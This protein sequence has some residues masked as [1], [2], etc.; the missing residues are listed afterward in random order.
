MIKIRKKKNFKNLSIFI[1]VLILLSMILL[2]GCSSYLASV[3]GYKITQQ[4]VGKYTATLKTT[5]PELF[6]EENK[7]QLEQLEYQIVDIIIINKII[8]KYASE[9]NISVSDSEVEDELKK[10]KDSFQNEEEFQKYLKDSN[11]ALDFLKSLIKDQLLSS[12][13]FNEITK[14]VKVSDDEVKKYYEENID[15]LF[16]EPEQI[17]ISYILVKYGDNDPAKKTKEEALE[18]IK[19]IQEKLS[20][21]E[22][23][24][25]LAGKYSEDENTNTKG[26]DLGYFS[27]GELIQEFESVAFSLNLGE[28]SSVIETDYGFHLIKLTD[29]KDARVKTFGEVKD[30]I[31]E[32]LTNELKNKKWAEF[33]LDLKN[34]AEIK[35][36]KKMQEAINS[37]STTSTTVPTQD[38]GSE[39]TQTNTTSD[40]N[41]EN[42]TTGSQN[43]NSDNGAGSE[44]DETSTS[45]TQEQLITPT[46]K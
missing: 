5:N 21:G 10:I 12:K 45:N 14:D 1:V 37:T 25:N 6:K 38:Q 13:V 44:N 36:S 23:F 7:S 42:T 40:S 4:D 46:T 31:N 28:V 30:S 33:I 29:Y 18:K 24:E 32:Y 8:E 11:M 43:Q 19:M 9:N 22:S 17:K 16:T 2:T 39:D 41:T 27:K 26:G 15:T 34:K 20:E 3:N 35:Y